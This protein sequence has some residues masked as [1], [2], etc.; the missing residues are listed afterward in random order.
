[1]AK[2]N[3]VKINQFTKLNIQG[4]EG[5]YMR[6]IPAKEMEKLFSGLNK[7]DLSQEEEAN[8]FLMIIQKLV[9]TEDG[10]T[11]DEFMNANSIDDVLAFMSIGQIKNL[12]T[13]L[14]N[15][16]ESLNDVKTTAGN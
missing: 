1:M 5:F 11:F 7:K 13:A 9:C 3:D 6:E 4:I 12:A 14:M 16:F 15:V 10:D 2:L 8:I